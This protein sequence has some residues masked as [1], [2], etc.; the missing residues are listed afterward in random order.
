MTA[1]PEIPADVTA[2]AR[3]ARDFWLANPRTMNFEE[4]FAHAI[5]AERQRCVEAVRA[6]L[7]VD[8]GESYVGLD[9]FDVD[10][11][12]GVYAALAAIQGHNT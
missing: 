9:G 4:A 12:R 11:D 6:E 3:E 2:A 10:Y 1:A 7:V 8:E 5:L